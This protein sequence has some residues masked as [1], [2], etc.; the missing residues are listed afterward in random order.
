[1]SAS[2]TF[3]RL[4]S[5]AMVV[6][7]LAVLGYL[8]Y[9]QKDILIQHEW[10][11]NLNFALLSFILFTIILFFVANLWGAIMN[12]LGV[13]LSREKHLRYYI[14]SNVTK[15][16]PGTVWYIASRAHY[17]RQ[18]GID[19][20]LTSLASGFELAVITLAGILVTLIFGIPIIFQYRVSLWLLGLVLAISGLALHPKV[21]RK[22]FRLFR[23]S[24][25]L[26]AY[27]TIIG[28]VLF[29]AFVWIMG[30]IVLFAIANVVAQIPAQNIAYFIGGWS[31]VGVLST[32]TFF[33]PTNLG[34]TEVGLSL[35]LSNILPSSIAVVIAVLARITM[36]VY[37]IV[38]AIF[39]LVFIPN[40]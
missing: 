13:Q 29:Y 5:F 14:I 25:T 23:V 16:I 19:Y 39:W 8:V 34:I 38:W 20:K 30:G 17:Y 32:I 37:E 18:D 28:W 26:I 35:I 36:M 11:F 10:Q 33:L 9:Q 27:K 24:E 4:I 12:A 7:T 40:K 15:R 2:Q 3:R 21:I 1:M 31:L 22:I 6:I